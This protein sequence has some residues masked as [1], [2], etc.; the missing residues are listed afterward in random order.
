MMMHEGVV[1]GHY[2]SCI[3][4]QVDPTKVKVTMKIP[5]PK[6]QKKVWNFLGHTGYY[7]FFIE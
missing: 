7:H 3:G 5:I 2:I 1:L 4:I 6:T